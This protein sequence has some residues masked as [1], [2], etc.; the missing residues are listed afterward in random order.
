MSPFRERKAITPAGQRR[1][2]ERA[3]SIARFNAS[4]RS[5]H[6][7]RREGDEMACS[8]GARWAVGEDHP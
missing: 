2:A 6:I 1:R 5:R 3:A 4:T 8:C 7:L